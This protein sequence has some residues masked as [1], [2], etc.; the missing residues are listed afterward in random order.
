M[1]VVY[2]LDYGKNACSPKR[3]PVAARD[4]G[5]YPDASWQDARFK[6]SSI[7]VLAWAQFDTSYYPP[8][9]ECK[10]GKWVNRFVGTMVWYSE[11]TAGRRM[12]LGISAGGQLMITRSWGPGPADANDWP[13]VQNKP[14]VTPV[15]ST[16]EPP[17][18]V[19]P[20]NFVPPA[21]PGD[22]VFD[23]DAPS[24]WWTLL[25][26]GAIVATAIGTYK[27]TGWIADKGNR[28]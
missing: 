6:W 14:G 11:V 25:G 20:T 13:P 19:E 4:L 22:A 24:G 9:Y 1:I 7:D 26:L 18:G 3:T 15:I 10:P 2:L 27:L 23:D 17:I 16:D 5:A 12:E 28:S 8:V 21:V